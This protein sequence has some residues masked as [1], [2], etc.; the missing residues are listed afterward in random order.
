M[1]SGYIKYNILHK[2]KSLRFKD[3]TISTQTLEKNKSL[4]FTMTEG[5]LML[6]YIFN[7]SIHY[8]LA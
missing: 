6:T 3:F 8:I 7:N 4:A 5:D 1:T 2:E